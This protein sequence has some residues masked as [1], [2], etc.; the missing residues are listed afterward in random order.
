MNYT[1]KN[2]QIENY[3]DVKS[4]SFPKYTSQLINWANNN[5]QGTRPKVVGKMT[6]LFPEFLESGED[7]TI[8]NW[9]RWY[10][11]RYPDTICK[12]T[13]KIYRQ[14]QNFREAIQL[15]DREMVE[16]WVE[17]LII[18][19]TFN[20]INIQKAILA[21][22]AEKKGTTFRMANSS[23]ESRGIDGYVGDTPYSIKPDTYKTMDHLPE[24]IDVKMIYYKKTKN[25]FKIEVED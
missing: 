17:D 8:E 1:L 25:G 6:E 20:G 11:E 24:V 21:S 15:I 19:K 12:A 10:T 16:K 13:D 3:N 22:L 18:V 2:K 14:I 9:K 7:V 5:A 23:E 4:C